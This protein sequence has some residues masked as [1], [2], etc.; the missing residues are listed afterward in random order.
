MPKILVFDFLSALFTYNTQ[1]TE[2]DDTS[3]VATPATLNA[4]VLFTV[5]ETSLMVPR[6]LPF[7]GGRL[8]A[9]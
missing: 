3:V 7:D 6:L 9:Y 8:N 5:P 4:P 1:K 2:Y